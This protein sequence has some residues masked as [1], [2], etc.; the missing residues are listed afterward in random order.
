MAATEP[1]AGGSHNFE[2]GLLILAVG[3]GGGGS[4]AGC[5]AGA[6]GTER[7]R[8]RHRC[9]VAGSFFRPPMP[10][11]ALAGL[12]LIACERALA[13]GSAAAGPAAED[14]FA[15]HSVIGAIAAAASA[16]SP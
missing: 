11:V 10:T 3:G 1:A 12:E 6:S 13:S 9:G 7:W 2:Y 16:V 8:G 15:H 5:S 4:Q 14:H